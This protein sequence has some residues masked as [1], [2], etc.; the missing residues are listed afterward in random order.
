MEMPAKPLRRAGCLLAFTPA[1]ILCGQP[2]LKAAF[3]PQEQGKPEKTEQTV[4][5]QEDPR[6]SQKGA[7]G[8]GGELARCA[9]APS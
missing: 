8:R 6:R 1:A 3:A 5:I 9:V 2:A 7:Q 4:R